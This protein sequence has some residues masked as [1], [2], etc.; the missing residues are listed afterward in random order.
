M[1]IV[2]AKESTYTDPRKCKDGPLVVCMKSFV[3]M[4]QRGDLIVD[5]EEDHNT[6]YRDCFV[7]ALSKVEARSRCACSGERC[8][9]AATVMR[10]GSYRCT[11][12]V[13]VRILPVC[14][15]IL[16]PPRT[17]RLPERE[18]E[19]QILDQVVEISENERPGSHK[20]SKDSVFV[21]VWCCIRP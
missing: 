19:K 6:K 14:L 17:C 20:S 11:R 9:Q 15:P 5:Q 21:L 1:L 2:G 3:T 13:H 10:F 12:L 18:Q 16:V 8:S 4:T 7:R